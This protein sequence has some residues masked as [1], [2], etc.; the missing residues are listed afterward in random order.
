MTLNEA[1]EKR[2]QECLA[3]QRENCKLKKALEEVKK[4]TYTSPEKAGN[5]KNIKNQKDITTKMMRKSF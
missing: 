3:L 2:R 1:Y 4:E 5:L